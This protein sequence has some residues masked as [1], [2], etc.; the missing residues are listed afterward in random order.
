[1]RAFVC[2]R[3]VRPISI[4]RGTHTLTLDRPP[5]ETAM[6]ILRDQMHSIHVT[7]TLVFNSLNKRSI[8]SSNTLQHRQRR[9]HRR[10]SFTSRAILDF[11]REFFYFLFRS[12]GSFRPIIACDRERAQALQQLQ[13]SRFVIDRRRIF[14]FFFEFFM[15]SCIG[16]DHGVLRCAKQ[17]EFRDDKVPDAAAYSHVISQ[18]PAEAETNTHKYA[19]KYPA[20]PVH[21]STAFS[22]HTYRRT[23]AID[24]DSLSPIFLPVC[25]LAQ[26]NTHKTICRVFFAVVIECILFWRL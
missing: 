9:R 25:A 19:C 13:R 12:F 5:T 1:M 20:I 4:S 18:S 10:R 6:Y 16:G 7:N 3:H 8:Y 23:P 21:G 2:R 26:G 22:Q 17:E 14:R 24:C 11:F 15:S